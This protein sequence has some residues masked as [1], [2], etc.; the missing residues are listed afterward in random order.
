MGS[1]EANMLCRTL[2]MRWLARQ[3]VNGQRGKAKSNASQLTRVNYKSRIEVPA[4]KR[5]GW[6]ASEGSGASRWMDEMPSM[7]A[8]C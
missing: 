1:R 3:G 7:M 5:P 6:E 8:S 4:H 2:T